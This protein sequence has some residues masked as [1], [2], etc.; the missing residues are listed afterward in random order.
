M[1]IS[2]VAEII[3]E[4]PLA[5]VSPEST[6]RQACAEM[7]AHDVGAVVVTDQGA[8]VG[9]LSERD[10]VRQCICAGRHTDETSVADIM[11]TRP[12]CVAPD[13]SLAQA[14][15][16]MAEGGFHHVPVVADGR[17]VGLLSADDIPEEYRMLLERFREISGR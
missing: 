9:L 4:Q 7:C 12:Q 6:V 1:I 13:G 2:S 17:P 8:L 14:L 15:Q 10:V 11:T 16:I 5:E 3:R